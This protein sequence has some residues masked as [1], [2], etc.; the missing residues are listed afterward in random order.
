MLL[1]SR[2]LGLRFKEAALFRPDRDFDGTRVWV[3]RGTKGG[4]PRYLLIHDACQAAAIE[5]ARKLTSKDSGLIP[6]EY[7]TFEKWRQYAYGVLRA[8]GISRETDVIFH[9]IRRSYLVERMKFLVDVR[10]L[11]PDAAAK[12]VAREAGHNRTEVL[13]WYVASVPTRTAS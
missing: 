7:P 3:K 2:H 13:R 5:E 4:R 1:L 9:D 10:H 11:S 12:I 8:A 6:A